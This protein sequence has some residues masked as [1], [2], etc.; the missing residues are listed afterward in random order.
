[1]ESNKKALCERGWNPLNYALLMDETLDGK[2]ITKNEESLSG[3]DISMVDKLNVDHGLAC[4]V[5]SMLA[6]R[7]DQEK[8]EK[9]RC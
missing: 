3:I 4:D 9:T 1:V 5:V 8:K 2:N 7:Q 6:Q